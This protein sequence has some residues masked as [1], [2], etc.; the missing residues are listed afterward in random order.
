MRRTSFPKSEIKVLL[1]EGVS[2]SAVEAFRSA[3]YTRIERHEKALE[4]AALHAALADTHIL[5]IR[6]R[7]Q[8]DAAALDAAPRLIAAGCFCIGTNQVDLAHAQRAGIP[9]FNA[10]YS[11]TRSVAELVIAE[12]IMLLRR[13]PE[14]N[15]LCH[16]GGWAKSAAG[17]YEVRDKVLGIVGYGHIGTQVG[18][19]AESLGMRVIFHDIE[20]K[21]SL[22]N[23]RPA[24]GLDDLLARAD[25]VT[26]HVPETAA[27]HGMIGAAELARMKRGASLINASRGTVVDIDALA[28]ALDDGQIGGAAIDVFPVE[29]TANAEPFVSPLIGKDNVLLTP[30]VGGSTQEAQ[31]SIGLEVAAKLIRYS[32]NGSTLSAVNFPEVALP[33]HAGSR[34]LLHIHRN[35][36]GVLTRINEAFSANGVN[37]DGQYLQTRGEVGYVVIDVSADEDAIQPLRADL[38]AIPGTLRTRALY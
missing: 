9:V 33:E 6:S 27:T 14:K 24:Q 13:I 38:A 28:A 19:L 31:E 21:L 20:T 17:S 37:I 22:G 16:R 4:P 7:T 15:A 32:D 5:G 25:V 3:G 12:I 26:L 29:P 8:L 23:A 2:A 30:H 35:V 10:P 1:L 18:V 34:R 11:N 36:P